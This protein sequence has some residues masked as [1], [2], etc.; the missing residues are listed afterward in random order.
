MKYTLLIPF[1]FVALS[2]GG[3]RSTPLRLLAPDGPIA[4]ALA[5]EKPCPDKN[6]NCVEIVPVS[7]EELYRRVNEQLTA[8]TGDRLRPN[9][10]T[11]FSS[12]MYG[13]THSVPTSDLQ[14]ASRTCTVSRRPFVPLQQGARIFCRTPSH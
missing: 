1:A 10:L 14:H 12:T 7:Y 4:L 9:R 6:K 5:N 13:L 11:C 8:I 2:C 3:H